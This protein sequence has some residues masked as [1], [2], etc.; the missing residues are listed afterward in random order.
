MKKI[1]LILVLAISTNSFAQMPKNKLLKPGSISGKVIDKATQETLPYVNIVVRDMAK[2]ILTGGITNEKGFFKIKQ[3]PEGK[4]I[5]EV[6]FI[7][8]KTYSKTITISSKNRNLK[9]GTI[10]LEEDSNQLDEVVVRA[11]TSTIVQKVDRKVITVG[12]DLTTSGATA[13]EIMN[14]LPSVNVDQQSGNISLRGNQNVRVMVDGKLSNIPASQLLKQ[15]PSNSIKQVELITNPSAKY[16][17]EGMSGLINIILHKNVNIG[18][19]GNFNTRIGY[20]IEPKFTSSIDANYRNGKFNFYGSYSNNLSKN[21]NN[22][23][24]NR[25]KQN[26]LQKIGLLNDNKSHLF[27]VGIDI[28]LNDK[29][30]ISLFT[31]QNIFDGTLKATTDIFPSNVAF[32]QFQTLN[33]INDNG[34]QQYNFNYKLDFDDEG[35]HIEFEADY[36]KYKA[37]SQNDN[38]FS[39]FVSRPNFNELTNTKRNRTSLNLDYVK[40]LSNKDKLELGLEARTFSNTINYNSNAREINQLGQYIPTKTIFDYERNIYAAYATYSKKINKWSY[41]LGVR[42]ESVN[43]DTKA[44][45]TDL[46]SNKTINIP[47][48]NDYFQVYPSAFVTYNSSAKN[49][50]QLSY[51]RRVDRPGVGQVNP[52]PEWNTPLIS[53][54]GNQ[55]LQP[56]FTNSLELNYTR[57]LKKGSL[58]AGIFYRN[59]QDE[60]NQAA[61][62]DRTNLNRLILTNDNFDDTNAYGLEL[63]TNYRPTKWWSISSSFDF[64]SQTQKSIAEKLNAPVNVATVNDIS[65]ETVSIDNIMWNFRVFNNFK[66]N[67]KL[68]FS[69]FAMYRGK[70]KSIQF[71]MEPMYFVNLGMRYSFLN[72]R[73]SLSLNYND[74]FNTMRA[75]FI[76]ERPFAQTGKFNWESNVIQLGFSYRFGGGKNRAKSRRKRNKDEKQGG[77]FF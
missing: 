61:L 52:L 65:L 50:Y 48:K 46:Q 49:S 23:E 63:S 22:G 39:G 68:S 16:N 5:V 54:F 41:Q 36:N 4:N 21:V 47:F 72:R 8:Y 24:L 14:N 67:Q 31:N 40:P 62:I 77:G 71:N 30:T 15:I 1:L 11:E 32:N 17:P 34:S 28:Y 73:A 37:D 43:V 44:V 64:Y 60:I 35:H 38:I 7:G 18:F 45:K 66:V 26:I 6:Q 74:V 3:I 69:A 59:I 42:A 75:K 56:Q 2:K 53:Q 70:N 33:N 51:S 25:T 29:N 9:L 10:P 12:K 27:K 76:G 20:D 19:N 55:E 13:S 58:T 57:K